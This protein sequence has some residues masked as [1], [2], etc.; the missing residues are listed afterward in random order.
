[1][2]CKAQISKVED[3]AFDRGWGVGYVDGLPVPVP[4]R[5][6]YLVVRARNL[7]LADTAKRLSRP[8]RRWVSAGVV[9]M[10]INLREGQEY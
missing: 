3:R 8:N 4:P 5:E 7:G 9:V 1:M 2:Q 6:H 10:R